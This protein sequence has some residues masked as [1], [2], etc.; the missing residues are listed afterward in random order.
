MFRYRVEGGPAAVGSGAIIGLSNDQTAARV[1]RV[2]VL[3]KHEGFNVVRAK[4][5]LEFKIGEVIR[6]DRVD[7]YLEALLVSLD[8]PAPLE[9][10]M[11]GNGGDDDGG[12]RQQPAYDTMTRAELDALADDRDIDAKGA[13]NKGEVIALLER[14]D[15]VDAALEAGDFDALTVDELRWHAGEVGVAVD[16]TADKTAIIALLQAAGG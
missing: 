8:A 6:L 12:N 9:A 5:A 4:E 14:A 13:K 1:H 3:E 16:D 15:L 7:R 11:E 2:D 10:K